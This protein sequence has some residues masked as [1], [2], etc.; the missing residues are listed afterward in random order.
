[1]S[2]QVFDEA[3]ESTR[4]GLKHNDNYDNNQNSSNNEE[5]PSRYS[6]VSQN[7][8]L[9]DNVQTNTDLTVIHPGDDDTVN[10]IL[11]IQQKSF[12]PYILLVEK[13]LID[14]KEFVIDKQTGS[15]GLHYAAHFGNIKAL[16]ALIETYQQD[17]FMNDLYDMNISHYGARMDNLNILLYCDRL[18]RK[19]F[20]TFDVFGNN[21][22]HY[23]FFGGHVQS[24]I[25]LYFGV[26]SQFNNLEE[27][28][29]S[30]LQTLM[31]S[32]QGREIIMIISHIPKFRSM[33]LKYGMNI[34]IRTQNF[35]TIKVLF[36]LFE[37]SI[38]AQD[39][40]ENLLS[41]MECRQ[42]AKEYFHKRISKYSL[43]FPE[44]KLVVELNNIFR[45]QEL[46]H[47]WA[48][49][50]HIL[51]PFVVL[52]ISVL[53]IAAFILNG[54]I[55]IKVHLIANTPVTYLV[56]FVLW[57]LSMISMIKFM[58]TQPGFVEKKDI[59]DSNNIVE[60]LAQIYQKNG[61]QTQSVLNQCCFLCLEHK[62]THQDHCFKCRKCV[63]YAQKHSVFFNQ[64]VGEENMLSYTL[65][66]LLNFIVLGI[67][68]FNHLCDT[69]ERQTLQSSHWILQF[70]EI[71]VRPVINLRPFFFIP[72]FVA[73]I[74]ILYVGDKL[75]ELFCAIQRGITVRQLRKIYAYDYNLVFLKIVMGK[76][77]ESGQYF[78][79]PVGFF[80]LVT[81]TLKFFFGMVK[82]H[83][84]QKEWLKDIR[85]SKQVNMSEIEL[86][87]LD[88]TGSNYNMKQFA[89]MN[90]D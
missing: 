61:K 45:S 60:K 76:K 86:Q 39:Y 90:D 85:S 17:P 52:L 20:N 31:L 48:S 14:P 26:G 9:M 24:F 1:M 67:I 18:D 87:E 74:M 63:R 4:E 77:Q 44:K 59:Q 33:L 8:E 25:Y 7:Q 58:N 72:L 37:G 64:C 35:Q 69:K 68:I 82:Q 55:Q 41:L 34:A 79:N 62:G 5:V 12:L 47:M 15:R 56:A 13:E 16:K 22:L 81:N 38:T 54:N 75:L 2:E 19:L 3:F 36:R 50:S 10:I 32:N 78:I 70:F 43:E 6:V 28:F 57:T 29:P 80:S 71:H 83:K 27:K 66:I 53:Y 40:Q 65:F 89:K 42:E 23:S 46:K 73:E 30:M 51:A 49:A 21:A 84:E 88:T 11:T